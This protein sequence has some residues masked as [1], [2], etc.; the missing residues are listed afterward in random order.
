MTRRKSR[1][2]R[3]STL[4]WITIII[5]V[6]LAAYA[7]YRELGIGIKVDSGAEGP[8]IRVDIPTIVIPTVEVKLPSP[9]DS[10]P[11]QPAGAAP[12]IPPPSP[13]GAPGASP[14][15]EGWYDI[16]FTTPRYPDRPAY[17]QGGLDTQLITLINSAQ[18]TIDIAA[19]DFDLQNVA[20]ALAQAAARGVRVRM[21][22]DSDTLDRAQGRQ[23]LALSSPTSPEE[24]ETLAIISEQANTQTQLI[25]QAIGIVQRANIPI[26][27]DQRPAIMHHKFVVV[28]NRAIWTGSWN[29]TDG[30]T[31]RLNNNAIKIV[32]TE[33]AQNYTAEFEKMFVQRQFGPNKPRGG[34]DPVITLQG[35]RI[36]NYFAPQDGVAAKIADRVAQAQQSIHFLAFSFTNDTIGQAMSARARA[37]VSVAGVFE[38]T[39]SETQ[40][41]EYGKMRR[42]KLDV[43]QDGNPYVMHH[44]VIIIDGRTVIFGSFNF[45]NNADRDNDENLLIVDDPTLAQSFEA[46]F[47]RVREVALNPLKK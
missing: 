21:V 32:S 20:T 17:H 30:D 14:E 42:A 3:S 8:V 4:K 40:Y 47:Q 10:T 11:T 25:Q 31:Y 36:E 37:G 7:I 18:Q 27:D 1:R 41:S 13:A 15:P 44:K 28:D 16:Y 5:L 34:T 24:R 23:P 22:T 2:K 12:T 26:V 39:G 9:A 33:L 35:V 19:Y 38:K 29:F 45:S 43:L 46:E 6:G